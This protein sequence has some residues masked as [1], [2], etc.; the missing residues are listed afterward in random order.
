MHRP[1]SYRFRDKRQFQS[2]IA[3]VSNRRVFNVPSP[4]RGVPYRNYVMSNGVGEKLE[5][6]GYQDEEN[7]FLH[8]LKPFRRNTRT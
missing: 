4:P 1:I 6:C 8:H 3:N 5:R 7:V 2:Q